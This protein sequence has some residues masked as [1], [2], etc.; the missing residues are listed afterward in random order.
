MTAR[1]YTSKMPQGLNVPDS[2]YPA[3][4]LN[5]V[6]TYGTYRGPCP[7]CNN[8]I[9]VKPRDAPLTDEDRRFLFPPAEE[10]K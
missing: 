1:I 8:R 10:V 2:G 4:I 7:C 5:R 3:E 6:E 9:V